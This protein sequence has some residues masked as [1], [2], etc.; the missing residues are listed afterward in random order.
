M[1]RGYWNNQFEVEARQFADEHR[2]R[3]HWLLF[4]KRIT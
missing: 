4:G 3:L 1:R 2:D